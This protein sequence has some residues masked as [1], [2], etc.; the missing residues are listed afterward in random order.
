MGGRGGMG[1]GKK[2]N[3]TATMAGMRGSENPTDVQQTLIELTSVF[4]QP[5]KC[6]T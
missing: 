3:I 1:V 2:A 4:L 5:N 6:S